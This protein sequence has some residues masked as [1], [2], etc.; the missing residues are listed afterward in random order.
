MRTIP[1]QIKNMHYLVEVSDEE[2]K[3]QLRMDRASFHKLCY[4]VRT[5][6]GLKSSRN[7]SVVEKVAMFLTILLH[8]TKNRCVKFQ[9]KLHYLLVVQPQPGAEDST[10]A[11]WGKFKGCLGALDG[12]YVDVHIP[13]TDKG[14]YRNHKGQVT[15]NVLGI[16]DISM[17]FVYVLTGWKGST[18][19][20]RVLCDDIHRTNGLK[21][22]R[23]C[24]LR[25]PPP[26]LIHKRP[27]PSS[28]PS[29]ETTRIA[30]SAASTQ[31]KSGHPRRVSRQQSTICGGGYIGLGRQVYTAPPLHVAGFGRR[32]LF[33]ISIRR[34][35][36]FKERWLAAEPCHIRSGNVS[37]CGSDE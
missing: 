17:K 14:R 36:S 33:A 23:I 25:P 4:L 16:C 2:C 21:V 6:G 35:A 19:D 28:S 29:S 8:H 22:P 20:S 12:T 32:P 18:T 5:V 1:A 31:S 37:G 11:Q 13:T 10:H 15:V 26:W 3:D 9:F 34:I 27:Q 7:V 30:P 24:V